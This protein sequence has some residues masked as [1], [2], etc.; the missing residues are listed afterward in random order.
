MKTKNRF[1]LIAAIIAVTVLH[2]CEKEGGE[3]ETKI[4]TYNS[5]ESHKEGQ[6]AD[7]RL[8]L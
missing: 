4:S 2:S 8:S 3:N 7:C 5:T 6:K 1:I